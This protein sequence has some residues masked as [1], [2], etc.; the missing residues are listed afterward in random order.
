MHDPLSI[1]LDF[2]DIVDGKMLKECC[3]ICRDILTN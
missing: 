1:N 2:V 3:V